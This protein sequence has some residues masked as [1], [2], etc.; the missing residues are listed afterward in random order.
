MGVFVL[1]QAEALA[2]AGHQVGVLALIPISWND[3][4]QIGMRGLGAFEQHEH[5]V[6]VS[7]LCYAQLP[8]VYS[9]PIWRNAYSG[10][11]MMQ[12]YVQAHGKP[13]VLHVHGFHS[14]KLAIQ[15]RK[16]YQLPLVVTEHNSR[17]IAHTLDAKRLR[18]AFHFFHQADACVAVSEAF[19]AAL[20]LQSNAA[21][22]VVPNAVNTQ[23]FMPAKPSEDFVFFSAGNFTI[24][25]NQRLQIDSFRAVHEQMPGAQLWLAGDGEQLTKCKAYAE[26]LGILTKVLFL[27]QLNREE[28][29]ERMQQASVFLI[30]SKHETFGVVAIEAM[31][32][33][34][35]VIATPCGG[36]EDT[37]R[38]CG[39]IAEGNV[40]EYSAAMLRAFQNRLHHNPD[41]A[42]A[43]CESRFSYQA[44]ARQLTELYSR[45]ISTS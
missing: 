18:F 27:G 19:R 17:F 2:Q 28:L 44:V 32:C 8:K 42:R 35:H 33:G 22:E 3:I 16:E 12:R 15:L 39:D 36:P 31:A 4:K 7:G 25:K 13:D 24:N 11:A 40:V 30:S 23:L 9:Y 37:V 14:G 26:Q 20:E 5:G 21:F 43:E 1:D 34:L 10:K 45:V 38:L 29:I 41:A 6:H